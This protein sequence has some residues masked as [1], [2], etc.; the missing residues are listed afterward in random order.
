MSRVLGAGHHHAMSKVALIRVQCLTARIFSFPGIQYLALRHH[1]YLI[2]QSLQ[3]IIQITAYVADIA[4]VFYFSWK[5]WI[6]YFITC[7][8]DL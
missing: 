7:L 1:M 2:Q 6:Y 4:A 5:T 8:C 3:V